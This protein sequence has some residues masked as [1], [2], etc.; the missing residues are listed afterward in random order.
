MPALCFSKLG[1]L[2]FLYI[3][4]INAS[5]RLCLR[6]WLSTSTFP[7]RPSRGGLHGLS[8]LL[9]SGCEPTQIA[10]SYSGTGS[11][12]QQICKISKEALVVEINPQHQTY[13]R[14][15]ES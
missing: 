2:V 13:K 4:S 8:P 10:K 15:N 9:P 3:R 1:G 12:G 7:C 14:K 6:S 5:S 11:N